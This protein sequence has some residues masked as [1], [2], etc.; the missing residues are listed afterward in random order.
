[1]PL[2]L[3]LIDRQFARFCR[4][5]DAEALGRVFDRTAKEL[6]HLAGWLG[7]NRADAEDLLQQTFL[8][9]IEQRDR[10]VG[11]RRVL[12]WLV[13]ILTNHARNLRRERARRAA[14]PGRAEPVGDPIAEVE[15][16]E[17]AGWLAGARG[18]LVS[19][20]REVLELHLE[21]GLNAKEI[22]ARLSRPAG[23]VR[24]QLVRALELLRRRLPSG[25]VAAVVP[26]APQ[27][28]VIAKVRGAVMAAAEAAAPATAAAG[29]GLG[30]VSAVT[31]GVLVGKKILLIVPLLALALGVGVYVAL[32]EQPAAAHGSA[33]AT[34]QPVAAETTTPI[35]AQS[36]SGPVAAPNDRREVVSTPTTSA[37]TAVIRGRC[38]DEQGHPLA[39][40]TIW[41]TGKP[42][43]PDQETNYNQSLAGHAER[44]WTDPEHLITAVDGR[45]EFHFTPPPE[46]CFFL[47]IDHAGLVG[48][49][50]C[51][52]TLPADAAITMPDAVMTPGATV[53]GR[54]TDERGQPVPGVQVSLNRSG[55]RPAPDGVL[56][57]R[58]SLFK[59]TDR[60][61]LFGR[62]SPIA[63]GGYHVEVADRKLTSPRTVTLPRDDATVDLT[64]DLG[65]ARGEIA[66]VVVDDSG[67]PVDQAVVWVAPR[68]CFARTTADGSFRLVRLPEMTDGE[69]TLH[70]EHLA[71]EPFVDATPRAWAT[72]GV[73][74]VVQRGVELVVFAHDPDGRPVEDFR[75][76]TLPA[77]GYA[78]ATQRVHAQQA[79][80][81]ARLPRLR[82]GRYQL[83]IEPGDLEHAATTWLP[84]EAVGKE[85]QRID[86]TVPRSA[87]RPLRVVFADGRPVAGT[88][89]RLVDPQGGTTTL[90][91]QLRTL[92]LWQQLP[93]KERA[94]VC[95]QLVTDAAGEGMLRGPVGTGLDLVLLGPGHVPVVLPRV[96]L[97]AEEPLVVTVRAGATLLG[98]VTPANAYAELLELA[99]LQP[100]KVTAWV[101]RHL[102]SFRLVT[103]T[104]ECVPA[105][106][107]P[108]AALQPDGT[109]RLEH[110][111]PCDGELRLWFTVERARARQ[112]F[113]RTLAH[114]NLRE[115]HENKVAIDLA[116]LLPGDLDVT[117]LHNGQVLANDGVMVWW[118]DGQG[119]RSAG[120]TTTT[121][122]AGHLQ[123]RSAPGTY[124]FEL[125]DLPAEN[126][127]AMTAGQTTTAR[128]F[129]T[130]GKLLL[131]VVDAEEK[132]AGQL[133]FRLGSPR[134][135]TH[136]SANTDAAGVLELQL[137]P[138]A[139]TL[140]TLP[141]RLQSV[142]GQSRLRLEH[143]DRQEY[144]AALERAWL[145]LGEFTV[146]AGATTEATVHLP[147]A[148]AK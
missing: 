46:F 4:T 56:D 121:D 81:I 115:D 105:L 61:G 104:G 6:L 11:Q 79:D 74:L 51:W 18:E 34:P 54:V 140:T 122:A 77:E 126:T 86:V 108:A 33:E 1:M 118:Q 9:A 66:G 117:V 20:Y 84:I 134:S 29:V 24:T 82:A 53:H 76:L 36:Q 3:R 17:F 78:E 21:Q 136:R 139:W 103:A 68:R 116:A 38:V 88:A 114:C 106:D 40:C 73:R 50:A 123:L 97:Q 124:S 110:L 28:A 45:Y 70:V 64:V 113:T 44:A 8:T 65:L 25:F 55:G 57:P 67:N 100:G 27:V 146:T 143:G 22:A 85:P 10:F 141:Q 119:Q 137:S 35:A 87:S 135:S 71:C 91:S 43:T 15:D 92:R 90:Q 41:F 12:P 37:G 32:P 26:F 48:L 7:G 80:G 95:Q 145:E 93:W 5:G 96:D 19:P 107:L 89:V 142:E 112:T 144:E 125:K 148:W 60:D 102:P 31:G 111:P 94:L 47:S 99:G 109:F 16:A 83:A 30:V 2:R 101:A 130:S 14:L 63:S 62:T 120:I 98:K 128:V 58:S 59:T 75:V 72:T 69:V 133:S 39:D 127:V 138:G 147:P 13:T 42:R 131:H 52:S 49:V 129:F 23:T 132:A